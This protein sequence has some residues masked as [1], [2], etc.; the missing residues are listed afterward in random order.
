MDA[1]EAVGIKYLYPSWWRPWWIYGR[2][3]EFWVRYRDLVAGFVK[4]A[5]LRPIPP[6][7]LFFD[8]PIPIGVGKAEAASIRPRPF[9]GGLR[10][11]HLH[12]ADG[13]YQLDQTQWRAF[14]GEVVRDFQEK[15]ARAGTVGVSELLELSEGINSLG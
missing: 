13:L 7:H 12:L 6:E 8:D 11:P 9:P 10:M 14:S 2:P 3:A 1:L 5:D 4:K 15:L